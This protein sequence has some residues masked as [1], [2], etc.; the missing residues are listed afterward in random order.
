MAKF[1]VKIVFWRIILF[2]IRGNPGKNLFPVACM[3]RQNALRYLGVC[4]KIIYN[5]FPI[6]KNHDLKIHWL[7]FARWSGKLDLANF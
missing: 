4:P 5:K 6:V 1:F 3:S 2:E 7:H